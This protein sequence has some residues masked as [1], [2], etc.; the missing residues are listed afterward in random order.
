MR[1]YAGNPVAGAYVWWGWRSSIFAFH[2][3]S[4]SRKVT[5]SNG[6]FS[7]SGVTGGHRLAGQP[8]DVLT[9]TYPTRRYGL[10]ADAL[11]FA[12]NNVATSYR[13]HMQPAEVNVDI[14]HAPAG[15]LVVQA[16]NATVGSGSTSESLDA[17]ACVANVLPMAD[18]DDVVAYRAGFPLT[19]AVEW[20]GTPVSVSAGTTATDPVDLDWDNAQHA[21]LAGPACQH[22]GSP[23]STVKMVLKG[24]PAGETAE[25]VGVGVR[26][27][28]YSQSQTSSGPSDTY[29]VSLQI[30]T[31]E[32]LGLYMIYTRRA[33]NP[34]SLLSVPQLSDYFEVCTFRAS[35]RFIHKGQAIRLSGRLPFPGPGRAVIYSTHH[36]VSGQPWTLDARGW[37]RGGRCR[38]SS[39][40]AFLS[41]ALYPT[42]TTTYVALLDD[43]FFTS[44]VK[45]TVR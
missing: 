45:V 10:E 44:V 23:G 3:G 30:P 34:D 17:G 37:A 5:D 25:F 4:T 32:P 43:S 36:Q 12:T 29:T 26:Q 9:V 21:Y 22:S 8:A 35:A 40:G 38:V 6:F 20:L 27:H 11:D 1:D 28:V 33:D 7:L 42:R 18:F 15:L 31:K 19:A 2:Y 13:Y 39:S 16:G 14:A 41:G 24:W